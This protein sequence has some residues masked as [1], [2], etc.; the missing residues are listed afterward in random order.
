MA[1]PLVSV[2]VP[3]HNAAPWLAATLESVLAQTWRRLELIVVDDGST[4][5]S[6][7]I[8][9]RFASERVQLLSQPKRGAASARQR[10]LDASQGDYLQYLDADDLLAPEKIAAQ[11]ARL[12]DAGPRV[13]ATGRWARFTSSIADAVFPAPDN[14]R[15]ATPPD[16]LVETFQSG[17]MMHPAAWL[18]PRPLATTAGP[19]NVELTLDDD[20]E[21]FTRVALAA[22]RIVFCPDAVSYYRSALPGSL[23]GS[24]SSA[25]W[26]SAFRVCE[27]STSGLLRREDSPRSRR[28]CA[29]YWLRFAFA[30][31]PEGGALVDVAEANARRLDAQV[32]RPP[33]GPAFEAFASVLG[34]RTAKRLRGFVGR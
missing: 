8:A 32:R 7:A 4:D 10:A 2:L 16:Y 23:S 20:G 3:C 1:E 15:D 18:T 14:W 29:L 28:A 24:R 13:V 22:N 6:G 25:A 12:R 5:E 31:F 27:L 11:V 34:W 30:A 17:G 33:S 9:R 21:Y 19:W 26:R